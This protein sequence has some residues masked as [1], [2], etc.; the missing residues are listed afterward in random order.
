VFQDQPAPAGNRQFNDGN[1]FYI[2]GDF[3][4]EM[5][6]CLI[7]TLRK[8]ID[9]QAAAKDGLIEMYINSDGGSGY[10]LFQIIELV[11]LAKRKGVKVRTIV[12]SHAYSCGSMLAITGTKGERYISHFAEHLAHHGQFDGYRKETP[13]QIERDADRWRRWTTTVIEHYKKYSD[14][15]NLEEHL[16]DDH[17]W[18]PADQAI[19]WGLADKYMDELE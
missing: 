3:D 1:R 15:P 10:L 6:W 16:K 17:F 4:D 8:E 13:L 12:S 7:A 14:I 18:I 5:E 2:N 11:E 19:K 9:T